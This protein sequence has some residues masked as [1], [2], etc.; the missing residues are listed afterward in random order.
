MSVT[1]RQK[2]IAARC[3]TVEDGIRQLKRVGLNAG[4]AIKLIAEQNGKVYN[5]WREQQPVQPKSTD[6]AKSP[7]RFSFRG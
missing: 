5:Q 7:Q 4:K 6:L 2:D 3:A 1:D